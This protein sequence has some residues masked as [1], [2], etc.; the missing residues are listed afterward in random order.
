MAELPP[1]L[2]LLRPAPP[3]MWLF[4]Q[5]RNG[6]PQH[7]RTISEATPTVMR[8]TTWIPI[9]M[10]ASGR[11]L[12]EASARLL[13]RWDNLRYRGRA[14]VLSAAVLEAVDRGYVSSWLAM[15]LVAGGSSELLEAMERLG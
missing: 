8:G 6:L 3:R 11:S 1:I 2:P 4:L 15:H 7:L 9:G 13:R 5:L 12:E 10:S 14:D